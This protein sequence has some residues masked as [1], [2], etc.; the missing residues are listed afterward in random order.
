MYT[1]ELLVDALQAKYCTSSVSLVGMCGTKTLWNGYCFPIAGDN[2]SGYPSFSFI[3][4]GNV[5]VT[6]DPETYLYNVNGMKF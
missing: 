1:Y 3:L 5:N 2:I 6:L 4:S